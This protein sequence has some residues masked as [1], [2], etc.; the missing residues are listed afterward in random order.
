MLQW[1]DIANLRGVVHGAIQGLSPLSILTGRNGC[2]KSTILDAALLLLAENGDLGALS[3]VIG[4]RTPRS[5]IGKPY[6]IPF[7]RPATIKIE[8]EFA[9]SQQTLEIVCGARGPTETPRRKP[10]GGWSFPGVALLGIDREDANDLDKAFAAVADQGASAVLRLEELIQH[11]FPEVTRILT[12]VSEGA[13]RT[14]VSFV[15]PDGSF[16]AHLAGDGVQRLF[17][18]ACAAATLP[19]GVLLMEEPE[20][21]QHPANMTLL[22]KVLVDAVRSGTQVI[23]TTHSIEFVDR[24]LS[25][26]SNNAKRLLEQVTVHLVGLHAGQLSAR[27]IQGGDAIEARKTVELELR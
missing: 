25:A 14:Y 8:G 23:L 26:S 12:R 6:L 18:T 9:A 17:L 16:P 11:A 24:I 15:V 10:A 13:Q 4:R 20:C 22:A 1:L 21:Y 5:D 2:G 7:G 27:T 3:R 19:A